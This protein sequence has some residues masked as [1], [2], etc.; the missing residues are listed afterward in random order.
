MPPKGV[1]VRALR[2]PDRGAAAPRRGRST[3]SLGAFRDVT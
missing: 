2:A 1:R 3:L